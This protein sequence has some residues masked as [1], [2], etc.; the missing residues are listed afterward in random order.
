M[1][2]CHNISEP[3]HVNLYI[4]VDSFVYK[5][6]TYIK[7][8]STIAYVDSLIINDFISCNLPSKMV[9]DRKNNITIRY[10]GGYH[11]SLPAFLDPL[12]VMLDCP[13]CIFDTVFVTVPL[14]V[15][16]AI[17]EVTHGTEIWKDTAIYY[18]NSNLKFS[19]DIL[20][21]YFVIYDS[22]HN[23][24]EELIKT[25]QEYGFRTNN[26]QFQKLL[27]DYFKLHLVE[28]NRFIYMIDV[29]PY[30]LFN[31]AQLIYL[32]Q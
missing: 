8:D 6:A 12:P 31:S 9:L 16:Y 7:Y 10:I 4:K 21:P 24:Y 11:D 22:T 2:S 23:Y 5:E 13:N 18:Q 32:I 20:N 30:W 3:T 15:S 17:L 14:V 25:L 27:G 1:S 29:Y 26:Q 28:K 19:Q